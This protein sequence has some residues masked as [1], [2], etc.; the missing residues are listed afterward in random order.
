MGYYDVHCAECGFVT[1]AD[2]MAVNI[3]FM[4]KKYCSLKDMYMQAGSWRRDI[5]R[6]YEGINIGMYY[7]L[8]DLNKEA[9]KRSDRG[10]TLEIDCEDVISFLEITYGVDILDKLDEEL[11]DS[12]E[13]LDF[14]DDS[15]W[16]EIAI[17]L[18][19]K[20]NVESTDMAQRRNNI[21]KLINILTEHREDNILNCNIEWRRSTDDQ[22]N[23]FNSCYE[24]EYLNI[25]GTA[26]I[27]SY[28]MV[29]P[30]CGKELG[31]EA[32]NY[33]EYVV[34]MLGSSRVGKTAY[35]AA[36]VDNLWENKLTGISRIPFEDNGM[37]RF[38]EIILKKYREGVKFEK[39]DEFNLATISLFTL[40]FGIKSGR[41]D[42]KRILVKFVDMPGEAWDGEDRFVLN[43]RRICRHA[44]AFWMCIDPAQVNPALESSKH[45]GDG[46]DLINKNLAEVIADIKRKLRMIMDQREIEKIPLAMILTKSDVIDKGEGLEGDKR[47]FR[48]ELSIDMISGMT[49]LENILFS[50]NKIKKE[51]FKSFEEI[52]KDYVVNRSRVRLEESFDIFKKKNYF[53]VAA[54]GRELK[55]V[56]PDGIP[57]T[58]SLVELPF[59]WLL[60]NWGYIGIVKTEL[61]EEEETKK[62]IIKGMRELI[63]KNTEPEM[64]EKDCDISELYI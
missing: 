60:A 3:D 40:L 32:G 39:T 36:L 37:K 21:K 24:V 1:T 38:D 17:S 31:N 46:K 2:E 4:V 34:V 27:E 5:S 22:G 14:I 15:F 23:E 64:Y 52:V 56:N 49:K 63:G 58:P 6:L 25:G 48:H 47:L 30:K 61:K 43:K 62:G 18:S 12:W 10:L 54:T 57:C 16:E 50:G 13:G 26:D 53:A 11:D 42:E 28:Q 35:L 45:P 8:E 7:K 59:I 29:C 19:E 44:S 41:N 55:E 51:K 9:S 20:L 33:E